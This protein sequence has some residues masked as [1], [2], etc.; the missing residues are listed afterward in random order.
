MAKIEI[1]TTATC[2]YC[3]QAKALLKK[4]NVA[5][6]EIHVDQDPVQRD[7]MLKRSGGKRTVP[8]IFINGQSIG[9][10]DDL[11]ALDQKGQLDKLLQ[12]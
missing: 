12:S 3:V 10:F 2:L 1:Y 8:Q 4:K 9:G 11:Y 6:Q 5:F 7:E